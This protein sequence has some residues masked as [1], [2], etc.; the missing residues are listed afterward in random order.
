MFKN[1]MVVPRPV[2][3]VATPARGETFRNS[4]VVPRN[5]PKDSFVAPAPRFQN[6][7]SL[8]GGDAAPKNTAEAT[9]R[10]HGGGILT[11]PD[12]VNMYLGDYFKSAAGQND[13]HHNDA[14]MADMVKNKGYTSVWAQYG[15]GKGTT[16]KSHVLGGHYKTGQQITEGQLR[17]MLTKMANS[18]ALNPHVQHA[19]KPGESLW[20]IAQG[21]HDQGVVSKPVAEIV[22]DLKAMNPSL[23]DASALAA[24]QHLTV[25][26]K[27]NPQAI[28]QFVLPP[29]AVLV[30]SDGTSSQNGLGGFHGN[31]NDKKGNPVYFSAICYSKGSNGIDFDGKPQDNLTI[32]ES[33][34]IS[35][36]AT[37]PNVDKAIATNNNKYLGWYDDVTNKG[38]IGDI[39][40]N[41]LPLDQTFRMVDGYAF[42]R[43][44]SDEDGRNEVKARHPGP[45]KPLP[46]PVVENS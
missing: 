18:G 17:S 12:V 32:T 24:G 21:L 26:G 28:Y 42:Q 11:H 2:S 27:R 33:H 45:V 3:P 30:M 38:E 40:I 6:E 9:L 4:F 10:Y 37:D 8:T 16:E 43:I 14:A 39:A 34:E 41:D 15:V 7:G 35:E 36:T 23:K 44:Y 46:K 20:S 31:V 29:D 13:V 19:V 5:A 1:M 25:Y 22:S